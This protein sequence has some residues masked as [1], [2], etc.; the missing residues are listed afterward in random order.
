M[1]EGKIVI[2]VDG[3]ALMAAPDG[4]AH[5]QEIASRE[6]RIRNRYDAAE[7]DFVERDEVYQRSCEEA[8]VKVRDSA[9]ARERHDGKAT[10]RGKN[11]SAMPYRWKV[12]VRY[13]RPLSRGWGERSILKE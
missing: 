8:F 4:P 3:K 5:I 13:T 10:D 9:S 6:I 1:S 12:G 7:V 2:E 11:A